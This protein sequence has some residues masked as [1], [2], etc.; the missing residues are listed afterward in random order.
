MDANETVNLITS[1]EAK[2]E[3]EEVAAPTAI[4]AAE[5]NTT[6][7]HEK[8]VFSPLLLR[9]EGGNDC[10]GERGAGGVRLP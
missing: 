10:R 7:A 5:E 8:R 9:L 3:E 6:A 2:K 4:N 1:E